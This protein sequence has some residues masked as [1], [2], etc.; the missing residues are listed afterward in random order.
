MRGGMMRGGMMRGGMMRGGMMRGGMMRGGMM[1]GGM[2]GWEAYS[3]STPNA[4]SAWD[5]RDMLTW[6]RNAMAAFFNQTALP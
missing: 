4:T 5:F 1:R 6:C 3:S 2:M